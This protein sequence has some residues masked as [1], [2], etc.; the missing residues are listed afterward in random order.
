LSNLEFGEKVLLWK[1]NNNNI[2][3]VCSEC[4]DRILGG[5]IYF[6]KSWVNI[7]A[8]EERRKRLDCNNRG[9]II[10][11]KCAKRKLKTKKEKIE[12]ISVLL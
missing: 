1:R 4:G 11:E 3:Y 12:F 7:Y 9:N 8:T 2:R 5:K 10:C 6:V